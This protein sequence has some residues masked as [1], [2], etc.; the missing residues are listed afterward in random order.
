MSNSNILIYPKDEL[1]EFYE[2]VEKAGYKILPKTLEIF[3]SSI[4]A[5]DDHYIVTKN[6]D[7]LRREAQAEIR[8]EAQAEIRQEAQK[9]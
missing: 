8:Q 2:D 3:D 6:L 4:V 7:E 9:R 5:E 1:A